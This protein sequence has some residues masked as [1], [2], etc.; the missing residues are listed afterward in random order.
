MPSGHRGFKNS[1]RSQGRA[2]CQPHTV[3]LAS[4][5]TTEMAQVCR[6]LAVLSQ[7]NHLSLEK[8]KKPPLSLCLVRGGQGGRQARQTRSNGA[9]RPGSADS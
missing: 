3:P 2:G 8:R 1:P 4:E 9:G 5:G 6:G 7:G